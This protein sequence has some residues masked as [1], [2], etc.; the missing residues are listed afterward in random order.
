MRRTTRCRP[1]GAI[2]SIGAAPSYSGRAQP[3]EILRNPRNPGSH[4]SR[5]SLRASYLH[6]EQHSGERDAKQANASR[7]QQQCEHITLGTVQTPTSL[8]LPI[9]LGQTLVFSVIAVLMLK[10]PR[11]VCGTVFTIEEL[12]D[13]SIQVHTKYQSNLAPA[14]YEPR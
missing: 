3:H 2:K 14:C 1:S 9:P 4:C 5:L 11:R 6:G 13:G 12:G 8:A 7:E 10:E